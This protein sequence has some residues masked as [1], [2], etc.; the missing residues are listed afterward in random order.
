MKVLRKVERLK[1]LHT[2][3][4]LID[5]KHKVA[6]D[7]RQG[8][9]F[10]GHAARCGTDSIDQR[11]R[12][13]FRR[14]QYLGR[15]NSL[16]TAQILAKVQFAIGKVD[17]TRPHEAAINPRDFRNTAPEDVRAHDHIRIAL[18]P[19]DHVLGA[20]GTRQVQREG[21]HAHARRAAQ[22]QDAD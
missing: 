11:G 3:P 18:G 22:Q 16:N 10:L 6:T 1:V 2:V 21:V 19:V 15:V 9:Y 5:R 13:R 7:P 17:A 12:E 20:A 8:Q 14:S 4:L